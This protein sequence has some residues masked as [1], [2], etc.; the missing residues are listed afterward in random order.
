MWSP[1][2]R[3]S[4]AALGSPWQP[5]LRA[6]GTLFLFFLRGKACKQIYLQQGNTFT[7]LVAPI[8]PGEHSAKQ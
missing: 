3:H 4:A 1:G 6:T 7:V 8:S 5:L 2:A